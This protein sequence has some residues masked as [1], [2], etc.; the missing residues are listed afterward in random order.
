MVVFGPVIADEDHR[1][2]PLSLV[3]A[4]PVSSLRQPG[5]DL[6]DQCSKRH[7]IPSALQATPPTGRGTLYSQGS[8][9][10]PGSQSA[11]RPAAR[12]ISL[13]RQEPES[14]QRRADR[15]PLGSQI[16]CHLTIRL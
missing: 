16:A 10:T 7:D 15:F 11:H 13:P 9:L 6:M 2:Q 14:R 3:L 5:G 4:Q 8:T 12:L 1:S